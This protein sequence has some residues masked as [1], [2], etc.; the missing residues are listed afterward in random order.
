MVRDSYPSPDRSSTTSPVPA[1]DGSLTDESEEEEDASPPIVAGS[2]R[3]RSSIEPVNQP[4]SIRRPNKRLRYT[5]FFFFF[6]WRS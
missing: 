1:L 2:K 3:R 5:F 4:T 6:F